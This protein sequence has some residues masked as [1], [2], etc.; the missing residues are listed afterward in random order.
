MRSARS[1]AVVVAL[2]ATQVLGCHTGLGGLAPQRGVGAHT[3]SIF[4]PRWQWTDD[5]GEAVELARFRGGPVVVTAVYTS[6][7]VRCPFTIEKLKRVDALFQKDHRP[8]QVV[9]VTLDPHTDTPERLA[10]F[11]AAHHLG[12]NWHLLA[13]SDPDTRALARFLDVRAIY[14]D[15]HIDHDVQIGLL[16]SEGRVIR[17]FDDWSFDEQTLL[18]AR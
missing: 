4:A 1:I 14:D 12:D 5:Q 6:C 17:R 15:G 9:L 8:L 18:G 11:K 13:G 7:T 10:R 16:D 3:A 2:F